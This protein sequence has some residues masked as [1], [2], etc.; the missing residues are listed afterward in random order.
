[1]DIKPKPLYKGMTDSSRRPKSLPGFRASSELPAHSADTVTEDDLASAFGEPESTDPTDLTLPTDDRVFSKPKSSSPDLVTKKKRSMPRVPLAVLI[2][3]LVLV[4]GFSGYIIYKD[5]FADRSSVNSAVQNTDTTKPAVKAADKPITKASPLTGAEVDPAAA[6][7]K[8][9]GIMIENSAEAR[10]QS[11]LVE[12]DMV[13]EAIAEGGIT[14]FLA[15]YQESQPT[16]IGPVRS[17]RPY[18]VQWAHMFDAAYVHAGGSDEGLQTVK[19][20]G[21]DDINALAYDGTALYRSPDRAA[22]HNLYTS[23]ESLNALTKD[24]KVKPFTSYGRKIDVPQT[25]TAN[26][27]AF[28]VSTALFN[29]SYIYDATTNSYA[30]SEADAPHLDDKGAAIK[31]KVVIAMAATRSYDGIYSVYKTTGSGSIVVFQ[32]GI[33]SEG[34]WERIA[35]TDQYTFK[36]KNGLS[37]LLN[38]GQTWITLIE[39]TKDVSYTP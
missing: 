15:L 14:R 35:Q 24:M 4:I 29:S 25:P 33:V 9:T 37:M 17:A 32:D 34:T 31:P 13:F 22:P 20:L 26:N 19:D 30:R 2:A 8:V 3:I 23:M 12:A 7:R 27:I 28:N 36:D 6:S 10:P 1:M 18:Y 21:I 38:K 16:K 39:D 5:K 11:G